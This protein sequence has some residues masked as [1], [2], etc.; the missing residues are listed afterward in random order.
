MNRTL[1]REPDW[2]FPFIAYT[3]EKMGEKMPLVLQLHGSGER[4]NGR[5]ELERVEKWGF[6]EM[7]KAGDYPCIFA[8]PQCPDDTF[9]VARVES[10]LRF[11]DQLIDRYPVDTD[12]IYLTG[13]SMGGYGTWYTAMAAPKRFAAIAPVCGG[14]MPWNAEVLKMPVWAFHGVID[15]SVSVR[16]SDDM[17]A[18]LVKCGADVRYSRVENVGH[19]VWLNAY[20]EELLSWLLEQKRG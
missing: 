12:R 15:A 1:H 18:E 5:E 13:L 9:W 10:V 3:P 16:E 14:G 19:R 20:N 4:G 8:F 7:A 2:V 17:V 6:P 11:L